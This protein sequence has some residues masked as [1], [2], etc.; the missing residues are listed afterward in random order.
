MKRGTRHR[1]SNARRHATPRVTAARATR[2]SAR[3]RRARVPST[4]ER[5][6]A[7][8]DDCLVE[9]RSARV[10][11]AHGRARGAKNERTRGR[12][13]RASDTRLRVHEGAVRRARKR[14][15]G[16][17]FAGNKAELERRR[18]AAG[19]RRRLG[20][21]PRGVRILQSPR[22]IQRR[23]G[24]LALERD[25]PDVDRAGSVRERR[26]GRVDHVGGRNRAVRGRRDA[27][28]RDRRRGQGVVGRFR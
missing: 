18:R 3:C 4:L 21:R 8:L 16:D 28:E 22:G 13:R 17:L 2:L 19:T 20:R 27:R 25:L 11:R 9:R 1:H 26:R 5:G 15:E 6:V 12:A 23:G 10:A 24:V 14:F 7:T